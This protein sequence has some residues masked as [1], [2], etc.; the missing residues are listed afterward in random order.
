MCVGSGKISIIAFCFTAS[1]RTCC[2]PWITCFMPA[3]STIA[4]FFESYHL[5]DFD[6]TPYN[7][8][9]FRIELFKPHYILGSRPTWAYVPNMISYGEAF[10]LKL[11]SNT[12]AANINAVVL[13]DPGT[14]TH[15]SNMATRMQQLAYTVVD[16]R[17]LS[18]TAPANSFLAAP[19]E[20]SYS[21][22]STATAAYSAPSTTLSYLGQPNSAVHLLQPRAQQL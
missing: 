5:E 6:I 14:T 9:E 1:R 3:G 19:S 12:S 10:I 7:Y 16:D 17:T 22:R 13:G 20:C 8:G 18:I 2:H 15:S 21:W 11:A 4:K